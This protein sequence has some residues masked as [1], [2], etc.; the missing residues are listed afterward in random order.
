MSAK[1]RPTLGGVLNDARTGAGMSVRQ[2]AEAAGLP[3][4]VVDRMLRDQL[5]QPNPHN[6]AR[7]AVVLE[8]NAADLFL[9]G[10]MPVPVEVPTVEALLRAEYDLPEDAVR[11]AKAQI[12][13]IV[14]RYKSTNS[15]NLKGGKK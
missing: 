6:I 5:E 13:A 11:E 9:L 10:G 15:R 2:L 12:E 4:S 14:S 8:L 7:L 3:K 1:N